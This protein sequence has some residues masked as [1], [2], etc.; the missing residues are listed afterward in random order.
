MTGNLTDS[1]LS[2]ISE[3]I[4]SRMGLHFPA[5]RRALLW[6]NLEYASR[7]FGYVNTTGF[8]QWLLS[9]PLKKEHVEILAAHLT[10]S[11]T[12]FWREP[13][14][15]TALTDFILPELVKIKRGKDKKIKIWSAGCSTGEEPYSIA[16]ALHKLIPVIKEWD[17]SITA[18]D[19]N[20]KAL[21]KATKGIYNPWSFRNPPAWMKSSYFNLNRELKYE[22]IPEIRKMVTFSCCSLTD[23]KY[24]PGRDYIDTLD[25]I[26]CRNVLMYFTDE[27]AAK[28]SRNLFNSLSENGWLIVSSCELSSQLFPNLTRINFP[29]VILYRKTGKTPACF[30]YTRPAE[31]PEPPS[32]PS[33]Y[34]ASDEKELQFIPSLQPLQPLQP[35]Q[36][37]QPSQS[38]QPSQPSSILLSSLQP[39]S[40]TTVVKEEQT[41]RESTTAETYTDLVNKIREL[42]DRGQVTEALSECREAI[43]GFKLSPE[44]YFLQASILLDMDRSNEAI[45]SL[46]QAIYIDQDYIMGHFMLGNLY[47][48]QGDNKSAKRYFNNTLSLLN[49]F[50]DDD[51]PADSEGLSVKYIREII[52]NSL[53]TEKLP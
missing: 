11:E 34:K 6:R 12:Y 15:F 48:R 18:T 31:T 43:P 25:I 36:P 52:L 42:A 50:S 5:E 4:A 37:V 13:Q 2:E 45:R 29:G 30:S 32:Q 27:W 10:V 22:I 51:L 40:G 17:I 21:A 24:F 23:E 44:L 26:F 9:A 46:K 7:E 28:I 53:Q 35:F 1:G 16:I 19:I 14:T 49:T 41:S 38:S 8:I 47:Y 20:S 3:V 33:P 39:L